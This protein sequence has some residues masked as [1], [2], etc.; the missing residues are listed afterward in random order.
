MVFKVSSN[1]QTTL[2]FYDSLFMRVKPTGSQQMVDWLCSPVSVLLLCF[3]KLLQLWAS[4]KPP[5]PSGKLVQEQIE[6]LR[7]SFQEQAQFSWFSDACEL[8]RLIFFSTAVFLLTSFFSCF[9]PSS[10][11]VVCPCKVT[12]A[13]TWIKVFWHSLSQ[14]CVKRYRCWGFFQGK[15]TF[16]NHFT[17][18]ILSKYVFYVAFPCSVSLPLE[19]SCLCAIWHSCFLQAWLWGWTPFLQCS[20]S[21]AWES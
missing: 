9:C 13:K 8:W 15:E 6:V 14:I 10:S 18:N 12:E 4:N 20:C 1:L 19:S 16:T 3:Q 5:N 11:S 17:G 2:R 21:Y 7:C